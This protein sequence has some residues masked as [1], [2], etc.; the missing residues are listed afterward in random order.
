M[1]INELK[2]IQLFCQ[3]DDFANVFEPGFCKHLLADCTT[4]PKRSAVNKPAIS[5]SEMMTIEI[6]YHLSGYK[7]FQYFYQQEVQQGSLHT[8]FPKAPSYNRF[9]ELKPRMLLALIAYLHC[10]RLGQL[11]SLYYADSTALK[12]CHN[13][14]IH[15]NKVFRGVAKRGHTSTGWFYGCKLFLVVNALG[16]IVQAF[17]TPGN[18]SDTTTSTLKKLFKALR[19]LA[20]A[21]KGFVNQKAFDEL[22]ANGL[23]LITA[24][25]SNMKNKLVLLQEKM[26]LK[27]RGMIESVIDIL[28]SVCNIEHTRHRSALNMMVNTYAALCAYAT[29]DRKPSIFSAV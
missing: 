14:R 7:C 8:Y 18:V 19:G 5:L 9:V 15:Q 4:L 29:F 3:T 10:A 25:R 11:L 20:F 6:L 24:I 26:L 16:Q 23:K 28:K 17:L 12:V 27:K 21:D 22:L 13:R 1:L 2:L